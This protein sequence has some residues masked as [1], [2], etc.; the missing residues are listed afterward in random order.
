[1]SEWFFVYCASYCYAIEHPEDPDRW[2]F[3]DDPRATHYYNPRWRDGLSDEDQAWWDS[4]PEPA[5][6]DEELEARYSEERITA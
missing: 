3:C 6:T 2:L 4:L 1:M 5:A